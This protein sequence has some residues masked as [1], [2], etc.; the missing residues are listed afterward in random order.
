MKIVDSAG[1]ATIRV[2]AALTDVM[3]DSGSGAPITTVH[4]DPS[5]K[6]SGNLG[7]ENL[8]AFIS[9]ISFEGEILDST[10]GER[11]SALS[12]RRIGAKREAAAD[13]SWAAVRSA[14][15][16]GAAKLWLRFKAARE[17]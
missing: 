1:P 15:N 5:A 6:L 2:R 11:L 8:A 12:D 10:T 7:S 16:Q 17:G 4:P 3:E 14:A 13:T 9:N